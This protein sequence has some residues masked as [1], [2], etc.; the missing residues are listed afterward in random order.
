MTFLRGGI[1]RGDLRQGVESRPPNAS[2]LVHFLKVINRCAPF[3]VTKFR[4]FCLQPRNS[5]EQFVMKPCGSKSCGGL[6]IR[7]SFRS[8]H[9]FP[10][11][12][13]SLPVGR[14][15]WARLPQPALTCAVT[16]RVFRFAFE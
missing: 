10:S 5:L 15:A 2:V 1:R 7:N 6:P 11:G 3:F 8:L 4:V 16:P 14:S 9:V 12:K 13:S